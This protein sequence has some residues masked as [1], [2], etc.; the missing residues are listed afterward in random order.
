MHGEKVL[1]DEGIM[2]TDDFVEGMLGEA[3]H[4]VRR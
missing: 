2:G 3:D 1:T 4:R